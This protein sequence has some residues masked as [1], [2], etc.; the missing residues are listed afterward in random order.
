MIRIAWLAALVGSVPQLFTNQS[1]NIWILCPERYQCSS[2]FSIYK[3]LLHN[4]M[5]NSTAY[6]GLAMPHP[7]YRCPDTYE[8]AAQQKKLLQV[9]E[10]TYS[11]CWQFIVFWLP[12]T[13]VIVS[14][15]IL[16]WQL[17]RN[18]ASQQKGSTITAA[19][20]QSC[21]SCTVQPVRLSMEQEKSSLLIQL[22]ECEKTATVYR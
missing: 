10:M 15:G 22:T 6:Y 8:E 20:K 12:A 9:I 4:C 5:D 7:N 14:Y 16:F 18:M 11:W 3:H 21:C 1:F 13:I 17:R 19:G 2:V